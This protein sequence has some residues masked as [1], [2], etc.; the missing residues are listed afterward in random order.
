MIHDDYIGTY[1]N[2]T[3]WENNG[4]QLPQYYPYISNDSRDTYSLEEIADKLAYQFKLKPTKI[5]FDHRSEG[6]VIDQIKNANFISNILI[7]KFDIKPSEII[8]ISG[9][10]PV[11]LNFDYYRQ[12]CTENNITPLTLVLTNTFESMAGEYF[13][14]ENINFNNFCGR[15]EKKYISMNGA[16]RPHRIF[17]TGLL[18][19]K[20]LFEQGF[21]SFTE[22]KNLFSKIDWPKHSPFLMEKFSTTLRENEHKLPCYLTNIDNNLTWFKKDDELFFK[23]ARFNIIQ[24]TNFFNHNVNINCFNYGNSIFLTE[25]TFRS[26]GFSCPF[27]MLNRPYTLKSL[28]E[29]GYRTFHPY[30]N[31]TYD[32]IE[33]DDERLLA[34]GE[35]VERLCK[36][37]DEEWA[38]IFNNIVNAL[39]H[40]YNKLVNSRTFW[41]K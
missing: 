38:Q 40:N 31:E 13:L 11:Q 21:Y 41:M 12:I 23:K 22:S 18:F 37:S 19:H 4:F 36:L 7:E 9:N 17:F 3:F 29:Y 10:L 27:L 34:V 39:E 24:E 14:S 25:K 15:K 28:R 20:N 35:E 5:I 16:A 33:D 2:G 32:L 30:I 1:L 8:Y 6:F 26:M